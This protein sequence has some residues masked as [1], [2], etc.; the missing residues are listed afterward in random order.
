MGKVVFNGHPVR[1]DFE[2]EWAQRELELFGQKE[3]VGRVH[4]VHPQALDAVAEA[5]LN[6]VRFQI[7][8]VQQVLWVDKYKFF[9]LRIVYK[10]EAAD[11]K[12][13]QS[14]QFD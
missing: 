14:F 11:F 6:L 10:R 3:H 7:K 9:A 8:N 4:V 1:Q 13:F 2:L 12:I 5:E